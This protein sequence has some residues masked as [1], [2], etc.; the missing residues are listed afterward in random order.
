MAGDRVAVEFRHHSRLAPDSVQET[1]GL[2]AELGLG[3]VVVDGPQVGSGTTQLV[4]A[5]TLSSVAY[6]RLHGRKTRTWYKKAETTGERLDSLSSAE[7]LSEWVPRVA[8]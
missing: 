2:L 6:A 4:R 5:F 3:H 7:E 8:E 1:M